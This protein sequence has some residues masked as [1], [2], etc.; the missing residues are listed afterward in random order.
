ME[1]INSKLE[2]DAEEALETTKELV[3]LMDEISPQIVIR[4]ARNCTFNISLKTTKN[5]EVVKELETPED[6]LLRDYEIR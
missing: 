2:L 1:L 3:D 4:G 6:N 5:L